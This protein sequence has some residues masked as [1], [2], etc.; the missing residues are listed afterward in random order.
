VTGDR[1]NRLR[2]KVVSGDAWKG[3][4]AKVRVVDAATG[5]WGHINLGGVFTDPMAPYRDGDR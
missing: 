5:P 3:R 2:K 4:R 1:N